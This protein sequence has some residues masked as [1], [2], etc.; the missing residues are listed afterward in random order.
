MY[1]LK[2]SLEHLE[3]LKIIHGNTPNSPSDSLIYFLHLID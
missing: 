3:T 2:M 1:S